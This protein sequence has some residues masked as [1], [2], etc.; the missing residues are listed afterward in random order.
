MKK[1]DKKEA[2]NAIQNLI[3]QIPNVRASGRK[4]QNHMRWLANALRLLE[5]IF[6]A[7]SRYYL[8]L[9]NF[10]WQQTG[11]MI[12]QSWDIEGAIEERHES[13]FREQMNQASGLLLAAKDHLDNSEISEVYEGKNTPDETSELFKIINLGANKLR[14]IIREI[15][16][17]E[18]DIQDKYED[19]LVANDIDYAREFPHIE[20]SSKQYVPDFSFQKINLAVEI[21][22]CKKDEKGLIAQLNDDILAYKTVFRNILFIIYD[23]GQIRD[24]DS[25]KS[26]FETNPDI[27]IQIIKH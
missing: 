26:S 3:D 27:I 5:E 13:A 8:T 14:K 25:F 21:K 19:L 4:S 2:I 9:A 6:G 17:K 15:P 22:L 7:N 24:E 16:E 10:S 23:L 12:F 11:Q 20:Y 1:W 18:K